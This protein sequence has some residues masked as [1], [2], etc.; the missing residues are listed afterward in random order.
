MIPEKL[1]VSIGTAAVMGL[2]RCRLDVKP[3]TAYLMTYTDGSC[4]ANCSFCPQA[5][6]SSSRK[7]L[8]SRVIW[9][10]FPTGRVQDG[11]R[12]PAYGAFVRVCLQ[13]VNYPGFL[14]DITALL[15]AVRGA[16][17]LPVSL[18][19]PPLGRGDLE[20]LRDAGLERVS[21]P[22]DAATPE[23]FDRVKGRL[24]GGPYRW[25][26]HLRGLETAVAALGPGRVMSNLII[27]L[28]ETEEEAVNLIQRLIDMDVETVL[29]AF[30]PI[31]GTTL[32]GHPPPPLESYR[33]VQL[34]RRLITEGMARFEEMEFDW[35]GSLRS[36]GEDARA[37]R[38]V[39]LSGEAFRTSGCPG[40]NR[41]YYNERPSG[42]FY[43][44]PRGLT[45]EEAQREAV[46]MGVDVI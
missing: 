40:C 20:M 42:P 34:A 32:A 21:V 46:M 22:L 2:I 13:A 24:A 12:Q 17:R 30:T 26:E 45:Q 38:E 23:L 36:F 5:R 31:P 25:E 44:Y 10:A 14:D 28:G 16:V 4:I 35:R 6:D 11:L 3:T 29:F 39:L 33:R 43:N 9:P 18:D 8:L 19:T 7:S 1:R 37:I 15:G 27:G 41:P